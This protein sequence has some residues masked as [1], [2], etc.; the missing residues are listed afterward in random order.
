[1]AGIVKTEPPVLLGVTFYSVNIFQSPVEKLWAVEIPSIT[2]VIELITSHW[3]TL[4][5]FHFKAERAS[6]LPPPLQHI[7]TH[8]HTSTSPPPGPATAHRAQRQ[9]MEQRDAT[10]QHET[11]TKTHPPTN[12][13]AHT[14]THSYTHTHTH[15]H[16]C[17]KPTRKPHLFSN[18]SLPETNL[19]LLISPHFPHAGK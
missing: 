3:F 5:L 14:P 4:H 9:E 2:W 11:G 7:H 12:P 13:P 8:A 15:L 1:M 19:K 10:A 6:R 18:L 17:T 16:W